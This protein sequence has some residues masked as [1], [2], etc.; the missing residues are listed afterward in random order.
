MIPQTALGLGVNTSAG[1]TFD[2][3]HANAGKDCGLD[4]FIVPSQRVAEY[5]DFP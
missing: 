1:Q 4:W 3:F 5:I 2:T